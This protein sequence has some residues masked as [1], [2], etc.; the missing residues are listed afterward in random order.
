MEN[1][2]NYKDLVIYILLGFMF[3]FLASKGNNIFSISDNFGYAFEQ[4]INYSKLILNI[5]ILSLNF[6]A[7][8]F[9]IL[10]IISLS[11]KIR[12]QN[13]YLS[14]TLF[15]ISLLLYLL[16]LLYETPN[17]IKLILAI[18][19]NS[20]FLFFCWTTTKKNR[21]GIR[22]INNLI[23]GSLFFSI[24]FVWIN[25]FIGLTGQGYVENIPR[26]FGI[27]GHP[28]FLGVYSAH[29]AI[30]VAAFIF[31]N[32]LNFKNFLFF[33]ITEFFSILLVVSSASRTAL[34]MLIF[35]IA[36][37]FLHHTFISK[38]IIFKISTFIGISMLIIISII[39]FWDSFFLI[40]ESSQDSLSRLGSV[41]NTRGDVWLTLISNFLKHPFIGNGY[42]AGA[43]ESSFLKLI[44]SAGILPGILLLYSFYIAIKRSI[45]ILINNSNLINWG[46]S[47][48]AALTLVTI[49]GSFF[50]GYLYEQGGFL[51]LFFITET[52]I[53]SAVRLTKQK[54]ESNNL[55]KKF[56]KK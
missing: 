18:I 47:G 25:V 50:E 35:G 34:L 52:W 7:L 11:G 30:I 21:F 37:L 46:L 19:F 4:N 55:L 39:F 32:K 9:F 33:S 3:L 23:N 54:I 6:A 12:K 2:K 49:I 40:I 28:N 31:S 51:V 27:T 26:Y 48:M 8:I 24:L 42:G 10:L 14:P 20:C 1:K 41:E 16:R 36:L 5:K 56:T 38:K 13:F 15:L 22:N 17:D 43:S 29:C 44:A 53:V 45:K